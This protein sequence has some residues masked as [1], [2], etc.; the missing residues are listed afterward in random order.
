MFASDPGGR[1]CQA[2]DNRNAAALEDHPLVYNAS[3][4]YRQYIY[5][6]TTTKV[7]VEIAILYRRDTHTHKVENEAP[8]SV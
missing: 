4:A 5:N 2:F 1:K 7:H 6:L 3:D 8:T